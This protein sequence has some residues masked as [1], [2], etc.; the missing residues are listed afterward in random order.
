MAVFALPQQKPKF[1]AKFNPSHPMAVGMLGGWL[2]NEAGGLTAYDITG[3]GNNLAFNGGATWAKGKYGPAV[4]FNG[5]TGYLLGS[6]AGFPTGGAKRTL[7]F[8]LSSQASITGAFA[9]YGRPGNATGGSTF[10]QII[11]L[12]NSSGTIGFSNYGLGANGSQTRALNVTRQMALVINASGNQSIYTDGTA[13]GTGGIAISTVLNGR[14]VL[15]C[16]WDG[17]SSRTEFNQV[18]I[19]AALVYSRALSAGEIAKLYQ[20]PFCYM[21]GPPTFFSLA[22]ASSNRRRRLLLTSS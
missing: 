10:Q 5:S 7:V 17:D 6:D 18:T 4:K 19:E 14:F 20:Q 11:P 21:Q 16:R 3:Q 2:F 13:D 1:G 8:W 9:S 22:G 12:T 15:G